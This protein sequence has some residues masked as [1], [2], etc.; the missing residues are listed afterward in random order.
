[1]PSSSPLDVPA[2]PKASAR[3]VV[4]VIAAEVP[5][6]G[7]AS[8]EF[9]SAGSAGSQ[10]PSLHLPL[11]L[12]KAHHRLRKPIALLLAPIAAPRRGLTSA[13]DLEGEK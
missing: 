10:A 6:A 1:M 4:V 7:S 3:F 11:P 5:S 2:A 12:P 8:A 13:V 9:P